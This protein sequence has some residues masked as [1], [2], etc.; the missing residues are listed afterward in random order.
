VYSSRGTLTLSSSTLSGNW[1]AKRAGG[2][3]SGLGTTVALNNSILWGNLLDQPCC[4]EDPIPLVK[5]QFDGNMQCRYGDVQGLFTA[6]TNWN[7]PNPSKHPGCRDIDPR[8]VNANGNGRWSYPHADLRLAAGSP[9]IDAGNNTL[10]P[11]GVTTDLDGQPRLADDPASA[12]TGLGTPPLVDLGAYEAAGTAGSLTLQSPG[13][14]ANN[15]GAAV[16]LALSAYNPQGATLSFTATGLPAGLGIDA[17]TGVISGTLA[18]GSAGT[19]SV[20]ATVADGTAQS[21]A[22]FAW[23]VS[24]PTATPPPATGGSV[25]MKGTIESVGTGYLV[26]SG[27]TVWITASTAIQYEDSSGGQF[28]VGHAIELKGTRNSDGSVTASQMTVE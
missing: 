21:S 18:T 23:V 15:E 7:P 4:G 14:Q 9:A 20:T 13:D 3:A 26:V 16:A 27:T 24:A 17:A 2:V 19:Y 5:M 10:V 28:I 22:T 25:E 12:D 1:A 8:F 11:A 6:P